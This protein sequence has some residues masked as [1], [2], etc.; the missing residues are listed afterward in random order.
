MSAWTGAAAGAAPG[1]GVAEVG[2]EALGRVGAATPGEKLGRIGYIN[3]TLNRGKGDA[4]AGQ[5]L[6]DKHC[7][8]CHTLFGRG[9]KLGPDLTTA[10]RK[11]RQWLLLNIVDPSA[12]VR[13]EYAAY[14]A[15][16]SDGRVLSGL[17]AEATPQAVTLVNAKNERT[18]LPRDQIERLNPSPVSLMPEK[19]LDTL[20]DQEL[21]DLFGYSRPTARP[22]PSRRRR[23]R[24][25][26]ARRS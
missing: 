17:V 22:P 3:L 20:D 11:N 14:D 2:G 26:R 23:R 19:L 10:D 5:L 4:A 21:R 1:R 16:T 12:V 18:V 9:T 7:A 13:L 24:A 6:F 25:S 8:S 15:V